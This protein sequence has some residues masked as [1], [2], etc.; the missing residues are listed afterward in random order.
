M[1]VSRERTST[2]VLAGAVAVTSRRLN[3]YV[4]LTEGQGVE[5]RR[6]TGRSCKSN[7]GRPGFERCSPASAN[8]CARRSDCG[9][10]PVTIAFVL[11]GLVLGA[12][13]GARQIRGVSS[14]LTELNTSPSTGFRV[15]GASPAP[16]GVVI[17]AIDDE[18][19]VE[20]EDHALSRVLLSRIVRAI[21]D[22]HPRLVALDCLSHAR[23][24]Q[25]DHELAATL[26]STGSI[27]ASIGVFRDGE[28]AGQP[29][30][31]GRPRP[32]RPA[33]QRCCGRRR[34]SA[35][36]PGL[37]SPI[38]RRIDPRAGFRDAR[39]CCSPR[40]RASSRP[41][42]GCGV[43]RARRSV[44]GPD[45]IGIA[46]RTAWLDLGYHLPIRY[47]RPAG[48]FSHYSAVA[49]L[50]GDLDPDVLRDRIVLVG[51]T[52]TGLGDV[53]ATPFDR[54]VPGAESSRRRLAIS[55]KGTLW[56]GRRGRAGSTQSSQPGFR[57]L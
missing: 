31:S 16:Q 25:A 48:T 50:G 9:F 11:T 30:R 28:T 27:V 45:R 46:G 56:S 10:L 44:I 21:A 2:L 43:R 40:P 15:A 36:P 39:R 17:V 7:G 3:Q 53:F 35:T 19:L 41:R 54:A 14:G 23:D 34:P 57:R 38:C 29:K 49:L 1:E 26:K 37:A 24:A 51:V 52:A 22:R 33:R 55:S 12:W 4:V 42:V 6:A 32:W 20:A 13:L 18:T 47:S 8:R 5:S